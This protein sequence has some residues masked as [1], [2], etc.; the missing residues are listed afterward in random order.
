MGKLLYDPLLWALLLGLGF[1]QMGALKQS[2]SPVFKAMEKY[3]L[4][5]TIALLGFKVAPS[6]FLHP[7]L[8]GVVGVFVLVWVI[9]WLTAPW[10]GIQRDAACL[11]AFGTGICGATAV[12]TTAPLL[13]WRGKLT[14]GEIAAAVAVVNF[15]GA[16][17]IFLVPF[18]ASFLNLSPVQGGLL[19]GGSLHAVGQALAAGFA[20]GEEQGQWATLIKMSRVALLLPLLLYL[21]YSVRKKIPVSNQPIVHAAKNMWFIGAFALFSVSQ[22]WITLPSDFL[23]AAA[24]VEK[25]AFLIAIFGMGTSIGLRDLWKNGLPIMLFGAFLFLISLVSWIGIGWLGA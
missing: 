14:S 24:T 8:L 5:I 1:G 3:G 15:L 20:M 17:G 21:N 6:Y 22:W 23:T 16:L 10:M 11:V 19:A 13:K 18:L 2:L 7:Y 12:A 25:G 9:A 4:A